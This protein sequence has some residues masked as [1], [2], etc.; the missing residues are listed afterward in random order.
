ML[1]SIPTYYLT[2]FKAPKSILQTLDRLRRR[3]LWAGSEVLTGGKCKV[4]WERV[5]RPK[6]LGGLGILI[7][8]RFA[9]ALRLRWLWQ[10]WKA[11]NK[12]WVGMEIPCDE[13]DKRLFATATLITLGNGKKAKFWSLAWLN[14][15]SPQDIASEIYRI[16][17]RKNRMV[18][19]ALQENCWIHDINL[20]GFNPDG[21]VHQFLRLWKES[22]KSPWTHRPRIR[23]FGNIRQRL[24]T[25]QNQHT[26][27]NS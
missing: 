9:R 14:G 11:E 17:I 21:L 24:N 26:L 18:H 27:C 25:W 12:P 13:T 23:S 10:E 22:T 6:E 8:S 19:V 3:F 5:C 20:Q 16:S 15:T 2:A 7:L 1:S 4:N